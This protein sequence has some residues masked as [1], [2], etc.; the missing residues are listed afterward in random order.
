MKRQD[1]VGVSC[2][3]VILSAL[4]DRH[5]CVISAR[6]RA[7]GYCGALARPVPGVWPGTTP[8]LHLTA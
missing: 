6:G 7:V 4:G 3:T 8:L 5:C 2:T 1:G